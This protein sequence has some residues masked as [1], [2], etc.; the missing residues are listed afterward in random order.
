M[1]KAQALI[2]EDDREMGKLLAE[3]LQKKDYEVQWIQDTSDL[4]QLLLQGGWDVV[5]TDLKLASGSGLE[6]CQAVKNHSPHLPVIVLTGHG[7]MTA[8]VEAIRAGAYDFIT[9]PVELH[10][11]LLVIERAVSYF[12]TQ[13]EVR[14]LREELKKTQVM[15][16]LLGKSE[17]MLRVYDLLGR[18]KDADSSVLIVGESGTGKELVARALHEES[19]RAREPFVAINCAAVPAHLL[20]SELFGHVRGAFTDARQS[21][22]GLFLEA[23]AGTLLLDEVGE[24]PQDMQ[25][26]LLRVLQER[27]VRPVGGNTEVP[28]SARIVAATNRNLET[29]VLEGRFREDLY[30]RLNVVQIQIPP[31]RERGNDILL[32]AQ[33]FIEQLAAR[34]G[35]PIEGLTSEAAQRL[36]DYDWPGNVRQLHNCMERAVTL[37]Q[38][39]KITPADLPEKIAKFQGFSRPEIQLD[40]EFVLPLDTIVDRY[41]DRVLHLCD[42]NKSQAA[43]LLGVDRRTLYRKLEKKQEEEAREEEA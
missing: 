34:M 40:P 23:G 22:Q 43:R 10:T 6:V 31:L 12:R 32:L 30:Y 13:E 15:G 26:K 21:R 1:T 25:A 11:L 8:A 16:R 42:G 3:F 39:S 17:A 20:E 18:V 37:T 14:L 9:K 4:S 7:T 19:V 24:M 5:L 41:I 36:L 28:I 2:V 29:E 38:H 35:R 33:C 27:R